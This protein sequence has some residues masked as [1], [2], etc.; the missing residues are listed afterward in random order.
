MKEEKL[1][2]DKELQKNMKQKNNAKINDKRQ[3]KN[4]ITNNN[5]D[6]SVM[7]HAGN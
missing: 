1:K 3:L 5:F 7:A 6:D 4:D 2:H